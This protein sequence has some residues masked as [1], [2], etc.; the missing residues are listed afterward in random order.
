MRSP[1]E[2]HLTD[3][4][5]LEHSY[6][7]GSD[8]PGWVR[9]LYAEDEAVVGKALGELFDRALH[10]GTVSSAGAAA[11]P[12]LAHAAV[13]AVHRRDDVLAFI[14]TTGGAEEEYEGE[15][16][17]SGFE[18]KVTGR[19]LASREL[20]GLLGLLRGDPD[21]EVRRQVVR[22]AR[23]AAGESRSLALDAL[24]A[25]HR[26]DPSPA[27]RAEALTV[28]GFLDAD[29]GGRLRAALEDP[30]PAVRATAA[31]G[32]LERAGAP[33]P[34][35]LVAVLVAD[36][37]VPDFRVGW[38]EWFPG[39]GNTDDRLR[40]LL[41]ADPEATRA[42]AAAWIAAGDHDGRGAR[43]ALRLAARWYGYRDEAVALLIAAL[44]HQREWY[45][46]MK[47]LDGLAG[48]VARCPEP[49]PVVEA[50]LP[51][52]VDP[53]WR[54][55]RPA[56]LALGL[57]GDIRLLTAVPEPDA[58]ALDALAAR[59][60]DLALRRR[61]LAPHRS[62]YG[63]ALHSGAD[64]LLDAL[65]PESAAP[66]L[67]ELTA[68]LRTCPDPKLVRF[69]GGSGLDDPEL[70]RLLGE[71]ANGDD[72]CLAPAA[73]VAAARLGADPELAL[74][75]LA[76]RADCL[77]EAA[78]LGPLG[79]PLLPLV[80]RRLTEGH[81]R[82]RVEAAEAHW[83]ITGDPARAVP[84]LLAALDRT[85]AGARALAVLRRIGRPLPG[86]QRALVEGWLATDRS[87]PVG[88]DHSWSVP[89]EDRLR[90][91]AR[92]LLAVRG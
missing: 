69:L 10:Q 8:V 3:W 7:S 82:Q 36:G 35:E 40:R 24:V 12:Y 57:A 38:G 63:G 53:D 73:A 31:L 56:Q 41:D 64:E 20:P 65:T 44:P 29:P 91:E 4:A 88:R 17:E 11:V 71:L 81:V 76:E 92:L 54:I 61:A 77:A 62:R 48:L 30:E 19:T 26:E 72:R 55:S 27:V 28:L 39:V 51:H 45:W 46:R 52:T 59:T 15:E 67:P 34:A 5:S 1:A 49:G 70:R 89:E 58:A 9:A 80:E 50:V 90:E 87:R 6:G 37:G 74:R 60:D 86:E 25:C 14:A 2:L 16:E 13:H 33:Y 85:A 23:W 32:L 21:P 75:L 83:R 68:L 43:R 79:A 47:V 84:G 66:L 42:V 22:V 78:L 18:D